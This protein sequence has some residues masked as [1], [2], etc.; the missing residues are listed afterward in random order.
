MNFSP[1]GLIVI[2]LAISAVS[3]TVAL[4]P[5]F[6]WL[7]V[8]FE[9]VPGVG[10]LL[11]CPYCLNHYL[12]TPVIFAAPS[13]IE[14]IIMAFAIITMSSIFGYMLLKYLDLLENV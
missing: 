14:G 13:I 11:R 10:K 3:T 5:P 4:T 1:A 7:R 9:N 6:R 12:A 8:L 2:A